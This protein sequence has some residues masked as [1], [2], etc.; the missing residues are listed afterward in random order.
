MESNHP[1]LT[2]TLTVTAFQ[3]GESL[4]IKTL[5]TSLGGR[6]IAAGSQEL[7]YGPVAVKG[8]EAGAVEPQPTGYLYLL[9]YGVAIYAGHSDTFI[10]ETNRLLQNLAENPL[11]TPLREDFT[12]RT[13]AATLDV[14]HTEVH[15]G[16]V[17]A[18]T[19]RI[20]M[21]YV[22]QSVALDY[23]EGLAD[24]LMKGPNAFIESMKTHGKL[25]ASRKSVVRYIG[26][27]LA[28]RNRIIDNLYVLDTPDTA[29]ENEALDRLDRGMKRTFDIVTRFRALEDQ[30]DV[31]QNNLELFA[32]LIQ[33]RE[34]NWLEIII[35]LLILIE[36]VKMAVEAVI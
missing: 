28:M 36:V 6:L 33:H 30:L 14:G 15:I 25:K 3:L 20:I 26:E 16:E 10:A 29:W 32:E 21:L 13:G 17:N 34:S 19:L 2:A 1:T 35:I 4:A 27:T 7:F 8:D 11:A 5:R 24:G 23:Y 31:V 18:D 22:G 9:N 12:I